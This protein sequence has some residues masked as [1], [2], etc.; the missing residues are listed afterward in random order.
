MANI[1]ELI[2]GWSFGKQA[3]VVTPPAAAIITPQTAAN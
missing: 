1:N 3:A 2:E